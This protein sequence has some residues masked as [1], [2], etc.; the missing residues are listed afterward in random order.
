MLHRLL[1]KK[2]STL[3]SL[4][5]YLYNFLNVNLYNVLK[6]TGETSKVKVC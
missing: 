5:F 3:L 6:E 1:I 2:D 4:C